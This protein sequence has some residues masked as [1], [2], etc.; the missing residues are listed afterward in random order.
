ME[1]MDFREM[2]YFDNSFDLNRNDEDE[3]LFQSHQPHVSNI[4]AK[5]KGKPLLKQ[6][7]KLGEKK[8]KS[9]S[10]FAKKSIKSP[11]PAPINENMKDPKIKTSTNNIQ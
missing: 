7:N 5:D 3:P 6:N 8:D 10:P 11:Y 2:H 4:S 1:E 9:L